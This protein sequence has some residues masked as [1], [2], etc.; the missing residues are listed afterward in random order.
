M[1][2]YGD[3]QV[4]KEMLENVVWMVKKVIWV[5]PENVDHQVQ[6]ELLVQKVLKDL[7]VL[8]DQEVKLAPKVCQVKKVNKVHKA[9]KA[10][11]V[12]QVIKETKVLLVLQV[13][14]V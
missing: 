5:Y 14:R 11:Q 4:T 1:M 9:S 2:V 7:K 8:K 10:I 12:L 3:L 13:Q 6:Q